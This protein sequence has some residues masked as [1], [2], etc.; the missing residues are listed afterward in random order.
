M[1]DG[2]NPRR[3]KWARRRS[4][5]GVI[6][7]VAMV[8]A[9]G[10]GFALYRAEP[11]LRS[12]I[13]QTLSARF[14]SKV[15]LDGFHVA[16]FK[17][18]QV[19][20]EGLRIFGETDPN[21]HE[22]GIQPI[23][24]VGKFSFGMKI[25]DFLRRPM[26]VD[27]VY[28][29][30]LRINLPPREQRAQVRRMGAQG[31]RVAII[32]NTFTFED[33]H[34]II[35]TLRPGKLPIEFDIA[36]LKMSRVG[37]NKPLRF[38]AKLTNPKPTGQIL[39]AGYF[40]PWRAEDPRETPVTGT[41]SFSHADLSTIKGLGGMLSSTGKYGGTFQKITVDGVT[42]TPD[43]RL[44][45]CARP[46][47]LH[48]G[49][50]AIVDGSTGDTY[51]QPVRAKVLDTWLVANGS[52]VKQ[53]NPQGHHV[54]LNVTIESG[55]IDDLLKLAVRAQPALT[56]TVQLKTR[57]DLAPGSEDVSKRL[58]LAGDFQVAEADF[59]DNAIQ[60]K[61]N[62]LSLRSSGK[63][64]LATAGGTYTAQSD[65]S[66]TFDLEEG[67]I[68]F[69]PLQFRVPGAAV[70][71][72]GNYSLDGSGLE[73]HGTARMDATLSHMVTGWKALLLKPVDPFFR[74]N[75]AGTEV[76]VRVSGTKSQPHFALDFHHKP[77]RNSADS[78]L[79]D[80]NPAKAAQMVRTN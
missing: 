6:L 69:S 29:S 45:T 80:R 59:S 67:V 24:D 78:K 77:D 53:N 43:F 63:P 30:G 62:L 1:A 44:A 15:E 37:E 27:T 11:I 68:S 47:P 54:R 5:I 16:L 25:S 39:S 48:T 41:Y 26:H 9:V 52:V 42:D 19:S 2:T 76:P 28:V 64:K 35:N 56:G 13:I 22:P 40:G 51:L 32:V 72:I 74:K 14:N 73:F 70:A 57:F 17:G 7:L 60:N 58:K 75:G 61:I 65:L 50:H 79:T 71:L 55:R 46:V 20:G 23:I 10:V 36:S 34:L 31:G 8:L 18:L 3:T 4:W 33:A 21:N 12:T 66:G 38:E 49:F